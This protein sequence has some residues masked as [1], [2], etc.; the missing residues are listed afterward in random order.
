M[1]TVNEGEFNDSSSRSSSP[2][3]SQS[4]SSPSFIDREEL[5]HSNPDYAELFEDTC[6]MMDDYILDNLAKVSSP[7]FHDDMSAYL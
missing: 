1:D 5:Q 3:S 2:S 7:D 6:V 4:S